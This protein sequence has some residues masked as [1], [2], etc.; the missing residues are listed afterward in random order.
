MKITKKQFVEIATN[1]PFRSKTQSTV[2]L[3]GDKI[4]KFHTCRALEMVPGKIDW[5]SCS[6]ENCAIKY[7]INALEHI[8]DDTRFL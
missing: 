8:N 6:M 7:W 2:Y 4:R 1:C 5:D 3:S